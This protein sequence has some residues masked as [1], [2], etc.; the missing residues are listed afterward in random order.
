MLET[1]ARGALAVALAR[2]GDPDAREAALQAEGVGRVS[3]VVAT[4]VLAYRA[5]AELD[6]VTKSDYDTLAAALQKEHSLG[7]LGAPVE[8]GR[9]AMEESGP[10]FE[11]RCLGGLHLRLR[12]RDV[13]LSTVK[14]RARSLLRLLAMHEGRP[15]HRE[16]LMEALWPEC[17]PVAGARNLQVLISSLRQALEPGRGR[18]DDTLVRRDGDAYL[19]ALPEG[20]EI[21]LTAFRDALAKGRSSTHPEIAAVAFGSALDLYAE[22]FPE[23]GPVE[24]VLERREQLL[25][26][27]IEAAT[28][29]AEALL[30]LD[31]PAGAVRACRRGLALDR[32]DAAL[33]RICLEA[34]EAAGDPRQEEPGARVVGAPAAGAAAQYLS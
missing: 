10:A 29:L 19:L 28:G 16:V 7:G 6:P 32:D 8:N 12:G 9:T 4:C 23:E 22:L 25:D 15:V 17:D 5:L 30:A 33:G 20:A 2:A 26:G 21:D 31:D 3:G 14:P 11:L 27:A 24:W 13:D 1:W 34:Y 18:G